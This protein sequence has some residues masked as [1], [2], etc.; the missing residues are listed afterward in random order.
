[1]E[2]QAERQ[3]LSFVNGSCLRCTFTQYDLTGIHHNSV[4]AQFIIS[5]LQVRK[6]SPKDIK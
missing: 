4:W 2:S 3:D 5:Y 1:M 6:P